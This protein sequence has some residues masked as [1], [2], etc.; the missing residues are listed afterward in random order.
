[1][2]KICLDFEIAL[3]FLRGDAATIEKLKNYAYREEI[4]ITSITLMHLL[5]SV[6]KSDVVNAFAASV[7]VLPFDKKAAQFANR[8]ALDLR[9][10]GGGRMT[11][12]ILTAA[13]CMAN[14]A[15]LYYK[16]SDHTTVTKYDG[17]KG[18][19]KV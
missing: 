1:M 15:F 3:D 5:E 6:N 9:E 7:T 8:I 12:S 17:I 11:D 2:E 10:K 18:L 13:I 19:R 16:S 14:D 4:C